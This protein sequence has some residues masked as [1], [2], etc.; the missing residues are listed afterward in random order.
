[1]RD[2]VRDADEMSKYQYQTIA[3]FI[4][5]LIIIPHLQT[6]QARRQIINHW[7]LWM[8]DDQDNTT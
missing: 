1:V 3:S 8:M 4:N 2:A 7:H 6:P 5:S